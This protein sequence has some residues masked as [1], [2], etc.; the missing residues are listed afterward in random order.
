MPKEFKKMESETRKNIA[1]TAFLAASICIFLFMFF[2]LE[3]NADCSL[4]AII[5]KDKAPE[6]EILDDLLNSVNSLKSQGRRNN[7]GWGIGYYEKDKVFVIRGGK[8]ADKDILYVEAVKKVAKTKSKIIVAHV[9]K[10]VTGCYKGVPN[11][12]PFERR[13]GG[14]NWLFGHN[15]IV[16]KKILMSLIGKEY[17]NNNLPQTCTDNPPD[18]WVGSELYFIFLLKNIEE[19][20][21]NVEEGIKQAITKLLTRV[22]ERYKGLNFFLTD[23]ETVWAF[24]KG[25]SLYYYEQSKSRPRYSVVATQFPKDKQ[26]SWVMIPEGALVV[27]KQNAPVKLIQIVPVPPVQKATNPSSKML[28]KKIKPKG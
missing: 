13:Q 8:P 20:G 26:G 12:H 27:M 19:K 5:S 3:A 22:T 23:G 16:G 25:R 18:S 6:K 11:P 28:D 9:R 4:W 7:D 17:L 21:G 15:G 14:K 2:P 24:R 1:K 10:A